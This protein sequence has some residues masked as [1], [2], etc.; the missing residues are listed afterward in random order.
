[1]SVGERALATTRVVVEAA[2]EKLASDVRV[3]DVSATLGIAEIFVIVSGANERQVGAIVDEIEKRSHLAGYKPLY[4]EGGREDSWVL[5]DYFDV[6]VH[7]QHVE[8]RARYG[9]DRLW[10]DCPVIEASA[11]A[12]AEG[13]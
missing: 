1:M 2:E 10:K 7:V 9:L 4:R 6:I 8:A 11:W 12:G 5:L 13:P 3:I